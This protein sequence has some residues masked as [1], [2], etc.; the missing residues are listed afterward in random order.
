[1]PE[2]SIYQLIVANSDLLPKHEK[3]LKEKRGFDDATIK[4][5][6]FR[7]GGEYLKDNKNFWHDVPYEFR[8]SLLEDRILIPY[9][10]EDGEIFHLRPHHRGLL[11]ASIHVY[12]PPLIQGTA[13]PT[14][15]LTEGEFKAVASCL[16]GVPAI[17]IPGIN[18]FSR[19][20]LPD[21]VNLLH[22]YGCKNVIICFDN[23]VK[24]DPKYQNFKPNYTKRYETYIYEYVMATALPLH[25]SESGHKLG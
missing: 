1:M 8:L 6:K 16:L 7:S 21:L 20:K 15:V 4:K 18:T 22:G 11:G 17:S 9:F 10:H 2:S 23:E 13:H 3:E 19:K 5:L 24:D 25:P 12:V 14:L